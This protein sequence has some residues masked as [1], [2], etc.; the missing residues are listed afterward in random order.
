[1]VGVES[2][3][4]PVATCSLFFPVQALQDI[5]QIVVRIGVG[6]VK[7]DDAAD[8]LGCVSITILLVAQHTAKM[9]RI[10]MFGRRFN[11]SSVEQ[12]RHLQ[13]GTSMKDQGQ[14]EGFVYG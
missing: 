13:A 2:N 8:Q 4:F 1:M 11:D 10:E 5:S 6:R 3:G 12:F 7:F 14:L 9:Q